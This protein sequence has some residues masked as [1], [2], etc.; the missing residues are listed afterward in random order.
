MHY[1][2]F[3]THLWPARAL[4]SILAI[5]ANSALVSVVPCRTLRPDWSHS[6]LEGGGGG[7]ER[8]GEGREEGRE[9]GRGAVRV[10]KV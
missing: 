3:P 5:E 6:T 8:G 9:G 7:E 2:I 4:L 1:Y 10:G